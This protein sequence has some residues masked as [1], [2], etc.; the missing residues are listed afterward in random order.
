MATMYQ[1]PAPGAPDKV[2]RKFFPRWRI[3]TWVILAFNLVMLLWAIFGASSGPDCGGKTGNAL[4][5][6]QA[7]Q[8]GTGIGVS[9]IIL[10]W[11]LGDIILGVLW[12]ITNRRN[13]NCPACG[14]SV[15]KGVMRCGAC[16]YDFRQLLRPGGAPGEAA[17]PGGAPPKAGERGWPEPPSSG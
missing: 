10:L 3:F 8:V 4:T 9:L 15:R 5:E 7:G 2:P 13:R 16:G 17:P 11:A 12:L 6:C 1:P 14:N